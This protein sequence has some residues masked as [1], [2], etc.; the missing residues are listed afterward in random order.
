MQDESSEPKSSIID[1]WK[2]AAEQDEVEDDHVEESS[3]T[4]EDHANELEAIVQD[5]A[6]ARLQKLAEE[7]TSQGGLQAESKDK[8]PI[9]LLLLLSCF[10]LH[11]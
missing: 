10:C 3:N 2:H 7:M 9:M 6:G 8:V 4:L 5:E 1:L 11:V